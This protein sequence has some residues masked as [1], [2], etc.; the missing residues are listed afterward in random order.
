MA[1]LPENG[2]INKCHLRQRDTFAYVI[3]S[4]GL[5]EIYVPFARHTDA[6]SVNRHCPVIVGEETPGA[7]HRSGPRN[8]ARRF[9]VGDR[10]SGWGL[11][12]RS[13]SGSLIGGWAT[14]SVVASYSGNRTACD[15]TTKFALSSCFNWGSRF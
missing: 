8:R 7:V 1:S 11:V 12:L 5:A 9:D 2:F 6:G 10:M 13:T 15:L 3:S 14:S 4:H